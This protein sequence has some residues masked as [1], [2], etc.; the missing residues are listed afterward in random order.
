MVRHVNLLIRIGVDDTC[1]VHF[2]SSHA[3]CAKDESKRTSLRIEMLIHITLIIL[4]LQEERTHQPFEDTGIP[5]IFFMLEQPE[6]LK[7]TLALTKKPYFSFNLYIHLVQIHKA[8]IR[9]KPTQTIP[10]HKTPYHMYYKHHPKN[11]STL[12]HLLYTFLTHIYPDTNGIQEPFHCFYCP[13]ALLY[14]LPIFRHAR[15]VVYLPP[16][17]RKSNN[18]QNQSILHHYGTLQRLMKIDY[19]KQRRHEVRR[20]QPRLRGVDKA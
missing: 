7:K 17:I 9:H 18:G 2:F 15:N 19:A 8:Y 6:L 1:L 10:H 5:G 16:H 13:C 20:G 11:Q 12:H 4:S 14:T 3:R